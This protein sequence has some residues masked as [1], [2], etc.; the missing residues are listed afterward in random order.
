MF[1]IWFKEVSLKYIVGPLPIKL[2]LN[3]IIKILKK[4][5]IP[6]R[7][8]IKIFNKLDNQHLY[9]S[10]KTK[11]TGKRNHEG[12]I[13][14][15]VLSQWRIYHSASTPKMEHPIWV[16]SKGNYRSLTNDK[17]CITKETRYSWIK[18]SKGTDGSPPNHV[19]ILTT[20]PNPISFLV[21]RTTLIHLLQEIS[22]TNYQSDYDY[23][24]RVSL[25]QSQPL[26]QKISLEL[27]ILTLEQ[28][29]TNQTRM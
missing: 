7:N 1:G 23:S 12:S 5:K 14:S 28:L 10:N 17:C 21:L 22:K 19:R 27:T 3:P 20:N 18:V 16:L 2:Q 15:Q 24:L 11:K 6:G 9:L 8:T 29:A 25:R 26:H 4:E 13:L